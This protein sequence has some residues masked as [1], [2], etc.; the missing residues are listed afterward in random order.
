VLYLRRPANNPF[1][2]AWTF[3]PLAWLLQDPSRFA[4]QST[5]A[6]SVLGGLF[7]ADLARHLPAPRLRATF[8][9][10]IVT[11]ATLFPL[12]IPSLLAEL[13]W[14]V[15]LKF[16]RSLDWERASA[17]AD[18]IAHNH[19]N[20]RLAA[21]YQNSFGPAIAVFTPL[22]LQR[23]HW[24][25]V[26]PK[27]DPALELSAG[28]KL[29]VVPLAPDDPVLRMM[30]SGGLIR[31]WGGTSDTAVVT[32]L[33]RGDPGALRPMV[34]QLLEENA[35]W[36]GDHASNNQMAPP[37]ELLK[38]IGAAALQARRSRM[39]VQRFHAGRMEMACLVYGY[40]L[41]PTS[42]RSARSFR[43]RALGFA[44]MG[45]FLSDDDP[46]GYISSDR[47]QRFRENMLA[48]ASALR[49]STAN[50]PFSTKQVVTAT[51]RLFDDYFGGA[52]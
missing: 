31:V 6:G 25:E 44:E 50:D 21:I 15:G 29:Y 14:D 37:V 9:A 46:L 4:A 40:A 34:L 11:L 16:P 43:N 52:A 5:M 48:L 12:G 51:D 22:V 39:D 41:E 32:L 2:F 10:V 28:V 24:V 45:S 17:I 49:D 3:S 26:Q 47:H 36:L 20:D 19:L 23:G 8:T 18:V 42:P 13:T 30:E 38:N 7:L 33:E 1:L 35:D 27:I